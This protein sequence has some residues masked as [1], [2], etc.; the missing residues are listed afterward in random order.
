MPHQTMVTQAQSDQF[1]IVHPASIGK[2]R[3]LLP[4]FMPQV[5]ISKYDRKHKLTCKQ[6]YAPL[7]TPFFHCFRFLPFHPFAVGTKRKSRCASA[8]EEK[9]I[10]T[11]WTNEWTTKCQ[12]CPSIP[13]Y[14]PD[15]VASMK[16]R[17]CKFWFHHQTIYPYSC[18]ARREK[19]D[20]LGFWM[21]PMTISW[22]P[23]MPAQTTRQRRWTP[24]FLF[25]M[26]QRMRISRMQCDA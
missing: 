13:E 11:N 12:S 20:R 15:V 9:E 24:V 17:P 16:T 2:K 5:S 6:C 19:K 3:N 10:M 22:M 23:G 14:T 1:I 18:Y 7:A 25:S 26:L 21:N 8:R 4:K